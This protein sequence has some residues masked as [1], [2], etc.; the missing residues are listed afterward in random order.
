MAMNVTDAINCAR[1]FGWRQCCR[2][3]EHPMA[4]DPF[5]LAAVYA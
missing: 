5:D 2:Q 3:F 1:G 4:R